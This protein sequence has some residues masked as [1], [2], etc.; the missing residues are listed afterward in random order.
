MLKNGYR[1]VGRF[2]ERN[3]FVKKFAKLRQ[4]SCR[5]AGERKCGCFWNY[6]KPTFDER[7]HRWN[8]H[9]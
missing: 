2:D 7:T 6:Q 5:K 8:S 1:A 9:K 3:N 4:L